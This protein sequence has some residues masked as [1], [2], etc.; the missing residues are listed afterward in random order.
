MQQEIIGSCY[1]CLKVM[2]LISVVISAFGLTVLNKGDKCEDDFE[3][4]RPLKDK[5]IPMNLICEGATKSCQCYIIDK[6]HL[7][8]N[9]GGWNWTWVPDK[10]A[11]LPG[12]GAPCLNEI[13]GMNCASGICE[14]S[15]C[16][17]TASKSWGHA[18]PPLSFL[19]L[20]LPLGSSIYSSLLSD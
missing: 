3:C 6:D 16:V 9:R 13:E 11:C 19:T 20:L 17:E 5:E 7:E 12:I 10:K 2:V 8:P 1:K 15:K 14:K 18:L 4:I